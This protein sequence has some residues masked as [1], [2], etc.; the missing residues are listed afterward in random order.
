[1]TKHEPLEDLSGELALLPAERVLAH[2]PDIAVVLRKAKEHES[3]DVTVL[4]VMA[5]RDR[6]C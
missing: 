6:Y 3:E 4:D 5:G 1:M 2:D